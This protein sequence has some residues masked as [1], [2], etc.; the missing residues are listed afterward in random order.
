MLLG[1][2]VAEY[3]IVLTTEDRSDQLSPDAVLLR[4]ACAP[5]DQERVGREAEAVVRS[6]IEITP[7]V[8]FLP[9]DGFAEIAGGYKFK[10]VIDERNR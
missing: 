10:R 9:P 7:E 6:A 4:L 5:G 3:Q 2:G 8:E 1:K